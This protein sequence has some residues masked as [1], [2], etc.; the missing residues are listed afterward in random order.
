M[1]NTI[2]FFAF[3]ILALVLGTKLKINIGLIALSFAFFLGTMAGGLTPSGVVAL[4]P[5]SLFFNFMVATFLFGFA[6]SNGTLRKVAA[7]LLYTCRSAGWLLGLLFFGVAV[8]V[9]GLGAGGSAPFFLSAI[10][11]SLAAQAGINPIL[12]SVALWTASMVG[13][14]TPWTS[15]YA[16]NVGQLEIYFDLTTASGY[17]MNFFAFRAVFYT[18][19]YVAMFVI[20][21]GYR[22]NTG[23]LTLE[24]PE[25]FDQK[26]R[27][28][29]TI[30][31]GIIAIIVVPAAIQLVLPNPVT[32]WMNT[33]VSF[34]LLAVVGIT[35]NI[36]LKTA[37]YDE[38][39][40]QRIPWDTLLMLSLTGM[41]MAL[42][43]AMGVVSYMSDLLQNTIPPQWI[44]PGVV[45]I[46]C[47]LSFFVSGGVIIPMMLPLL[48]VLAAA[49]GTSAGMIYCAAQMGLTASSIS[50]FSQG[51]AAVLT[52]CTDEAIR[53]KLIQEQTI[54]A[55]I[56]S[57]VLFLTAI[58]G[59]FQLVS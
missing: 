41:Y 28:T 2:L 49:S 34:Q 6:Q 43:N 7:H 36:L 48:S 59:G 15:G 27:Q 50:P 24:R 16:T 11:F 51:G 4:F 8:L 19:I 12:V 25:P 56:F 53:K 10:C 31:L 9:A 22:V 40:R 30:I 29:L 57:A 1:I 13:G 45:L 38:V 55:P 44:L 23:T 20:L 5:V 26:Q 42:A 46:M 37:D 33:Y 39:I 58:L 52:G 21:R 17:V 3:I 32:K 35:L 54:L 14:S 47:V 18:V